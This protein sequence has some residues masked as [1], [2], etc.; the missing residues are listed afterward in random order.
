MRHFLVLKNSNAP[1]LAPS[2]GHA[3]RQ[4]LQERFHLL[5]PRCSLSRPS[6]LVRGQS[7]RHLYHHSFAGLFRRVPEGRHPGETQPRHLRDTHGT[8]LVPE[9]NCTTSLCCSCSP[10]RRTT[11]CT[12]ATHTSQTSTPQI[13]TLAHATTNRIYSSSASPQEIQ[14]LTTYVRRSPRRSLQHCII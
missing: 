2:M 14:K 3:T 6:S 9:V 10:Y 12:F 11:I 4:T 7:P 1:L 5:L 8:C 13:Q